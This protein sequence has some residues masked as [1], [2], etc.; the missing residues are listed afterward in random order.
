MQSA[1]INKPE[2]FAGNVQ[3][4][5]KEFAMQN[6]QT[7]RMAA[8]LYAQAGKT[9]DCA[10]IKE[11]QRLIKQNTGIFSTFRG[12]MT[13]CVATL[14][15]LSPNPQER[16]D[17]ILKV[18]DLLKKAKFHASDFLVIAACQIAAQT[19]PSAYERV[20]TRTR[21]FY[22]GMKTAHFFYTG[23]DDYIFAAMLGLS[24]VEVTSGIEQMEQ[25]YGRLK[26]E[27]WDNNSVQ[28]LTQV[29]VLG[30]SGE[31][32]IARLM[33]LRDAMRAE[34]IKLDKTYTLPI[35]GILAL[36]PVDIQ[37]MV[38]DLEETRKTLKEQKG[39]GA[40]SVTGQELLLF[41]A[42]I[43]AGDY[44][45]N[46]GGE[47]INAALN[48]SIANIIMAQQMAMIAVVVSSSAAASASSSS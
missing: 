23:E 9:I 43:I 24:D 31:S 27:F 20:I 4:I 36:L 48:T 10:A 40:L 6:A 18:Y 38:H 2:L 42:A 14:L 1:G 47:V 3:I 35:L 28:T 46:I 39:L 25:L 17:E 11:C 37:V 16:F 21:G 32:V 30:G 45:G 33:E 34:K 13:I 41:A 29:L 12:D 22:D 8:L 7:K 26:G 19:E 44:A 15:A 5:K